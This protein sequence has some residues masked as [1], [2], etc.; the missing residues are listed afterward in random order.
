MASTNA[1]NN[2]NPAEQDKGKKEM[3]KAQ[4]AK[5]VKR[6]VPVLDDKNQPKTNKDGELITKQ[7]AIKEEEVMSFADYPDRVVVVTTSGEKLVATK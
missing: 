1:N 2:P 3:T 5:L 6:T 7:V 4:A